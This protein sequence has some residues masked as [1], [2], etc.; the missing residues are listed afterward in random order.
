MRR[1]RSVSRDA[2][3]FLFISFC[4]LCFVLCALCFVWCPLLVRHPSVRLFPSGS[5]TRPIQ[6][7]RCGGGAH[8]SVCRLGS[9][10]SNGIC[11]HLSSLF[12]SKR[13]EREKPLRFALP[14]SLPISSPATPHSFII[15]MFHL[16]HAITRRHQQ[17]QKQEQLALKL[18]QVDQ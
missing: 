17:K 12:I 14:P 1:R 6:M 13:S 2:F 11:S 3:T 4:A 9:Q 8:S 7:P 10:V 15:D 5:I 16:R 18:L